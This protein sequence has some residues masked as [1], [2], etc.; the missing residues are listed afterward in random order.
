MDTS[1][2][3]ILHILQFFFD[4]GENAS[5][6]AENVNSVYGP[7]TV[8]A[9]HAQFWFRRF[10]SGNF[11]VKDASLSGRPIVENVDKIM[12]IVESDRHV[13]T[14][15]IVQE[16]NIAQKTVWNHLN[17][18]GYKKKLDRTKRGPNTDSDHFLVMAKVRDKIIHRCKRKATTRLKTWTSDKLRNEERIQ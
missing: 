17:K 2:E 18:I 8:T 12:E 5:Q 16:L 14:V 11:D 3:K 9:N 7:D 4:K 13:S 10:R 6:A 1:K 15:S